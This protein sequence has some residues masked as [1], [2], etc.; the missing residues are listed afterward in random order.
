MTGLVLLRG[1][2]VLVAW[3]TWRG[4]A[5]ARAAI[6]RL[7]GEGDPTRTLVEASTRPV[8]GRSRVRV[9]A[10]HVVM[11]LSWLMVAMYGLFLRRSG[12]RRSGDGSRQRSAAVLERY[13]AVIGIEVHCQLRTRRKMF[14]GCASDYF[15]AEPNTQ[16]CSICLGMPG[17]LPVINRT[18]VEYTILARARAR[19]RDPAVAKFDRKNYPYPDLPEGLPDL[20]VR[21]AAL[22]RRWRS[23][24][25]STASAPR[26]DLER[27]HLEEDT[28]RLLHREVTG[29]EAATR[30][31]T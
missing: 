10:R 20:A 28:A 17:M 1:G 27:I 25:K 6:L 24:S 31:S 5:A 30:C 18:A 29:G 23:M 9:M 3:G 11:A 2:R 19:L 8:H 14:C 16:V 26:H 22:R 12:W 13:E 21:P 15:D 7:V 4:Y